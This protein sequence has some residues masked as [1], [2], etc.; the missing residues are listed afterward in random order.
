M[1]RK[2]VT[3]KDVPP[4]DLKKPINLEKIGKVEVACFGQEWDTRSKE[5]PLCAAQ[6]LCA[7]VFQQKIKNAVKQR[8]AE[9]DYFLDQADF[10]FDTS[11]L[12][13][14]CKE[15]SG[16]WTTM[17]LYKRISDLS[18]CRDQVAVVEFLKR[19]IGNDPD[20]SIKSKIVYHA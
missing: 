20:L 8:E 6:E 3:K 4:V 14:D 16:K 17:D 7:I 9:A 2:A 15:H 5:C 19:F 11:V 1:V 12:K 10:D 18:K 13:A